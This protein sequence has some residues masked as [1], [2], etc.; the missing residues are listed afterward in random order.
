MSPSRSNRPSLRAQIA[1]V[2]RQQNPSPQLQYGRR[3]G[4]GQSAAQH[5]WRTTSGSTCCSYPG[6]QLPICTPGGPGPWS[7]PSNIIAPEPVGPY[8]RPVPGRRWR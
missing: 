2:T 1:G 5:C 3:Y 6:Q 4:G 7:Q 8:N